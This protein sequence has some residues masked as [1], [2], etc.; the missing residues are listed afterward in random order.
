MGLFSKKKPG[1]SAQP[2]ADTSGA[3]SPAKP[4]PRA[5]SN[6]I[7]VFDQFGRELFITKEQ[8][9]KN[10]LPGTLKS[11]WNNADQLYGIIVGSLNDGFHADIIDAAE[12]LYHIDGTSAR[13]A[14]IYGIV[15]M[16]NN[17][18]NEAEDILQSY[19]QEHGEKGFLLTNLAK[20]YSA[21]NET[22]RAEETLWHALEIDPNQENGL[23]WYTA[24]HR[25]RSGDVAGQEALRRVA[26][27]RGSWRAQL[28]LARAALDTHDLA[29]ALGYY[30]ESLSQA[31][32]PIPSDLLMQ[33]SGDLGKQGH[34]RELLELTEPRFVPEL[35]G[36]QVGNNLIKA[37]LDLGEIEP[38]RK[39]LDQLYVL[40]R[41]DY[42]Q[43]LSFWDTE[44]AKTRIE[45]TRVSD[46]PSLN[47]A[48]ATIEGP[49]WL[50]PSSADAELFPLKASDAPVVSFLGFSAEVPR[51]S[52]HVQLQ[53]ADAP[54]RMS[55]A[56]P[57][58]LAEQL[59]FKT[60]ARVQ[61]LAPCVIGETSGFVLSGAP[62][63]DEDA[64]KYSLQAPIKSNFVVVIHLKAETEPWALELRLIR[65][66]NQENL[67]H[68]SVSFQPAS[69]EEAV[70][71]IASRLLLLIAGP[72]QL[73]RHIAPI[74]YRVP[75][76][77]NFRAYLLR[78]EQLLAVR[79]AGME[80]IGPSFLNGEREIID[81]NMQLCVACPENVATRLLFARTLLAMKRVRPSLVGEF[82]D[83]I[84]LLQQKHPLHGPANDIVQQMF[85]EALEP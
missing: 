77:V 73:Q 54:G 51:K 24:I 84:I 67:G 74:L 46:Q 68:L 81:G 85:N 57:L 7:R 60:N 56:L 28:W 27:L 65:S 29:K 78:L 59:W 53:I 40:K 50:K 12:R 70:V 16:K 5:D 63:R 42:K 58:F 13:G 62:W 79:C 11:N 69:P 71:D 10:V 66:S 18:L 20:V 39:I 32:D 52:E 8:W 48:I 75:T 17:R 49:V 9:R 19:I 33:I 47:V 82:K 43:H 25:E 76:G 64:A 3:V 83:K 26:V 4:D 6:V 21:R 22:Q 2:A 23:A 72:A 44:I 55:R 80:D 30:R 15:L 61:T 1:P 45:R 37:H 31:E 41:P 38:A 36:L 34:L 35:H 14:C